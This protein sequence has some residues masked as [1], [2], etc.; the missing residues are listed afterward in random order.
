MKI[1]V[2]GPSP[3]PYA[4][5]GAEALMWRLTEAINQL[6]SHQ[7][8]LIKLPC[9]E[10][11]FW[12]LIDSYH[13]FYRLD[14]SHFDLVISTKYPS[15]MVKHRNHMVYMVHHLRGLFDTYKFS[16]QPEMLPQ[17]MSS[18]LVLE[19]L[20]LIRG[21]D[22]SE[23][24]VE[25]VFEMLDCLKKDE[26]SYDMRIFEFP[27]P[28]IRELIHFFDSYAL[29]SQRIRR[30]TSISNNLIKRKDYFPPGVQVETIYP[31]SRINA[32][33]CLS[34]DYLFT[35]SRLDGPKRINLL[36][37]AMKYVPHDVK[38]KIAGIGPELERLNELAS[39]D[40]RVE[41]LNFVT[42][43]T[44]VDLYSKALA[45][46]YVPY[47]EDYGLITIEAMMSRKPV[48]T[49]SDSGGPLEFVK[50]GQTG[51]VAVPDPRK[52][53][54]K[55]NYLVENPLEARKM[56]E[57][58]CRTVENITWDEVIARLLDEKRVQHHRKGKIL[59][60]STYSCYPPRGGGQHRLYHL[61]SRLAKVFEVTICSI[62]ES[63]KTYQD[64]VLNTGLVQ[65]SIPQSRQHAESQWRTEREQGINLHD[66]CMISFVESS[67]GYVNK[68]KLLAKEAD[69]VIFAH[70]YLYRLRKYIGPN[71]S[72]VYDAVDVEYLQKKE[73]LKNSSLVQMVKDVEQEAC[74]S[75]DLIFATSEEEKKT[76]EELYSLSPKKITV[77]PNGVDTSVLGFINKEERIAQKARVGISGPTILFVGSWHPPNLDALL[78]ITEDLARK[79][80]EYIFL[81]V[82]SIKDYY[83]QKYKEFPKNVLAFGVVDEDEKHELYKLADFAINPMFRGSGTNIK[84]LD[85]M[86]AG[87]ATISTPVGARGLEIKDSEHAI[88]CPAQEFPN[89]ISELT[90]DFQLQDRL[91]ES[92]R[93]LVEEKYSWDVIAKI[94]EDRLKEI[95]R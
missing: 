39:R 19:I 33:Q 73:Y 7:A 86:S 62:I 48:I 85:Y 40:R 11:S 72:V 61:Y 87:I 8:E 27:G 31:P 29:S 63:N 60:L 84:M 94:A 15:W 69:V 3:V 43:K 13:Q 68:V 5:G 83:L 75:S 9:R 78:Y 51:Y 71:T 70:P 14:L 53:A 76:L 46:L 79:L 42:D 88:V 56:G 91:R 47:D 50:D 38:L 23:K 4:F 41:F 12:D 95:I 45:V 30:Y 16:N 49:A 21:A 2:V 6:T 64:L 18:G 54:E 28:L 58:A 26:E 55:I 20:N 57:K 92:G 52:I 1:A 44:L 93:M 10:C 80:P 35:A 32:F 77:V 65:L 81:I 37:E 89:N 59:V 36:V 22:P 17:H 25:A 90:S 67:E 82:G 66:V 24:E 34:Y 74:S